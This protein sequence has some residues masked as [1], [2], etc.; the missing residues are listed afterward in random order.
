MILRPF[1]GIAEQ[2]FAV[3]EADDRLL[4]LL[5]VRWLVTPFL[6]LIYVCKVLPCRGIFVCVNVRD[7][8]DAGGG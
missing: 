1:C 5:F 4:A 8:K 6:N 7:V 2:Q 3:G